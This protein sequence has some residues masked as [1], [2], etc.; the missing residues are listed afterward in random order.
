MMMALDL[1]GYVRNDLM[2]LVQL[3]GFMPYF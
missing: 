1:C 2:V 3:K